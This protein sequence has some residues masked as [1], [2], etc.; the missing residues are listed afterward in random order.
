MLEKISIILLAN[1]I[2]YAKSIC[3]KYSSDDI[4]VFQNPPPTRDKWEKIMFWLDGRIRTNPQAD[5]FLTILMHATVCVFIYLGFGKN[6]VS[7]LAA[8]LFA[9]NPT[10]NQ[11]S[12]WISG[13]SYVLAAIGMTGILAIPIL[14]FPF[15]L[16]AMYTNAGFI[17]PLTLIGS[18]ASGI[19]LFLP[20]AFFINWRRFSGNVKNKMTHEMITEDKAIK[21]E[22]IV[23]A[24]KT[25]G[26]YTTLCLFPF[27]N[28]FYHSYLQSSSGCGRFKAYSVNDRFFWI[29]LT[30]AVSIVLYWI[31]VPWNMVSF[32]LLW[33]CVCIAPFSNFMRMSQEIAERYCYLPMVGLM[34]VLATM[35]ISYPILIAIFLTAYAVRM[36]FLMDMYQDEYYL[37][38]HSCILDPSSWFVWHVRAMKR[39]NS[40]SIQE[41]VILWVMAHR[42]SP[43]EFKLNMNLATILATNNNK[44]EALE[45]LKKAE[46]NIPPG[47]EAQ[48]KEIIDRWKKGEMGVLL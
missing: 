10:T 21:P 29:G 4:P 6:D 42:I 2:F 48:S 37:L 32:G 12:V 26:F 3:F 13:R 7:F 16:L 27:R 44:K 19:L 14:G 25:F 36:W 20:L 5:H 8:L 45:Y 30:M 17:A 34:F 1:I 11:G 40:K 46:E 33:W 38:E 41:A 39:W 35:I 31:L 15:L 47:Q 23:L 43:N 22:K 9:F 24:L 18:N 28:A